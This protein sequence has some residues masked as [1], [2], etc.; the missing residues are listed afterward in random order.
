MRSA[1][2]W[3]PILFTMVTAICFTLSFVFAVART[4]INAF[5]PYISTGDQEARRCVIGQFLNV[6]AF[7]AMAT[8]YVRFK[9]VQ[10]FNN[11]DRSLRVLNKVALFMGALSSLGLSLVAN[12]QGTSVVS[13]SLIGAFMVFG[14][15]VVYCFLH[16]VITRKMYP[17]YNGRS[18]WLIRL[19][20]SVLVLFSFILIVV[21]AIIA[22]A[23]A[24]SI[25]QNHDSKNWNTSGLELGEQTA[26]ILSEMVLYI[27]FLSFSSLMFKIFGG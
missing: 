6:S 17:M 16:T 22:T 12:F 26:N 15:G 23:Q 9:L 25:A 3:L 8:M 11:Y 21:F 10:A 13:V 18:I 19:F 5:W 20:I 1:L 27:A 14:I 4:D 2:C 7:L 24:G